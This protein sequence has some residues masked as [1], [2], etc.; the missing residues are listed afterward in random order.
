MKCS[1]RSNRS[2]TWSRGWYR[3]QIQESRFLA[4]HNCSKKVT[5]LFFKFVNF[6]GRVSMRVG[7]RPR[8]LLPESG[9][10]YLYFIFVF[11][12]NF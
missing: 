2:S 1:N 10:P 3:I 9:F 7:A 6:G 5:K 11:K 4:R 12:R 8:C